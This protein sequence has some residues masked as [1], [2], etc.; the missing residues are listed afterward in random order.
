MHQDL[1]PGIQLRQLRESAGVSLAVMA[2]RTH[3]SEGHLSKVETGNRAVTAYVRAAYEQALGMEGAALTDDQAAAEELAARAAM[4]DVGEETLRRLEAVMDELAVA[5]PVSSPQQLLDHTRLHLAYVGRLLDGRKTLEEHR[6]LLVVGAWLSVLRATLHIDLGHEVPASAALNTSTALARQAGHD[7]IHAW[8]LETAA[9]RALTAGHYRHAVTLSQAAQTIAPPGSSAMAQATAQEGRAWARLKAP[10][11]TREAMSRVGV[12]LD[13]MQVPEQPGHH[14]QY[15]PEKF[16]AYEA[17]TLAWLGDPAAEHLARAFISTL[18]TPE[19]GARWPRRLTAA[20]L[21][22]A[23]A[24]VATDKLD[25]AAALAMTA[26]SSG[27][28]VASNRWR[29]LE[30]VREVESGGLPEARGL[31]EAYEATAP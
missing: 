25:E 17:T 7:E 22:L 29:A 27:V 6:R 3:F 12:L 15:D 16:A 20:N 28:L 18:N 30:I 5:Y 23:L 26:V 10:K 19:G 13:S 11:E 14:Y 8:C 1:E 31:R 4:S 2:V 24:L 9:W 21:D